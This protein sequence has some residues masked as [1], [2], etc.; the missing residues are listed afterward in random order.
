MN[1][2][3]A[4]INFYRD[5]LVDYINMPQADYF[6]KADSNYLLLTDKKRLDKFSL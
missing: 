2:K 5:T 3:E 1:D 4:A 6:K